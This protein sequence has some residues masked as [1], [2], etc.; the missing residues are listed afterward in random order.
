LK[1]NRV[2]VR[3]FYGR[4]SVCD[5]YELGGEYAVRKLLH[6][7]INHGH[8]PLDKR[9]SRTPASYFCQD[10]GIDLA[11]HAGKPGGPRKIGILGL[12]CGTLLA[13]GRAG[14]VFRI[15]EINPLVVKLARSEFTYLH[16]TPAKVEIVM[17]DGRLSLEREPSQQFDLLVM[18]AFS[19]D[20]VPVHLVSHEAF[21]IYFR[22]LK[23]E[24]ILAVNISNR[25]LDLRPVIASAAAAL[26]K[27]ALVFD[28]MPT[29]EDLLC[30]PCTWALVVDP[31]MPARLPILASGEVLRAKPGFR[32]WT[33]DFS[34]MHRVLR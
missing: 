4:L 5:D 25:Y 10:S 26:G 30:L 14:D 11:M 31:A 20:S 12:G 23:P 15:Y 3:N 33:D 1:G 22:H 18:D 2:V 21:Q 9:L 17:G 34:D 19:G 8:Q 27:T 29:E 16:D 28:Y 24:G 32:E 6:G 13:D 7:V